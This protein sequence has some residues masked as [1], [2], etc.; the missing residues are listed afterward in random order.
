M[1]RK[2]YIKFL[3]AVGVSRNEANAEARIAQRAKMSYAY[4]ISWDFS[5]W[6]PR[7]PYRPWLHNGHW[8]HGCYAGFFPTFTLTGEIDWRRTEHVQRYGCNPPFIMI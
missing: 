1:T 2:R 8:C 5:K 6:M 4:A 3:M 7:K